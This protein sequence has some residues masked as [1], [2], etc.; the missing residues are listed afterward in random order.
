MWFVILFGALAVAI[1]SASF[2]ITR[3]MRFGFV[4]RLSEKVNISTVFV[5]VILLVIVAVII[6][7][8]CG[9]MNAIIIAI[10]L[11]LIWI[12]CDL[13]A[14]LIGCAGVKFDGNHYV[15]GCVAILATLIY[16][17]IGY[18]FAHHVVRTDYEIKADSNVAPMSIVQIADAHVGTTM[19]GDKF[20]QYMSDINNIHPDLM[21][22]CGDL[23]D[24]STTR[25]NMIKT[26]E[27]LGKISTTYG[28]YYCFG[29]HDKG[30]KKGRG[31]DG[32]E[33]TE[34]L[35]K[36]GVTVLSDESVLIGSDYV[37]IGRADKSEK[38]RKP[39]SELVKGFED[40]YTI[41]MDHQPSDYDNEAASNCNLVLSGHTHGG[42]LIPIIKAGEWIGANDRTYGYERRGN[43]DFIVTSGIGDW[44][45]MFKTGCKSEYNVINIK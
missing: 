6:V 21:L 40:K 27:A 5:S 22:I 30:Y 34:E 44:E 43:T 10:N 24:D 33:L 9:A 26:C 41:I 36:N 25:A 45:I 39:I 14:K 15:A 20:A 16:L 19:N 37:L 13:I 23:I 7:L 35:I 8:S 11:A 12:I 31:Y 29:N 18:Y 17:I 4:K 2:L 3:L 1:L 38:S 32:D 42:Q 28:T